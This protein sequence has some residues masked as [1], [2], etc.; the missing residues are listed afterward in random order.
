M[1]THPELLDWL[2][3]DFM[4]HGWDVKRLARMIALSGTFAQGTT[5]QDPATLQSDPENRWLARG[6][7]VRL[8][9]EEVRDQAL[10]ASGLLCSHVGGPSVHAYM[11]RESYRDAALQQPFI[12]DTGDKLHRRSIYSFW[13]R[14]LPPPELAA[15]DAPSREFCVVKREKTTSPA[16]ALMLLN[17]TQFVEAQRVLAQ[18]LVRDFRDD[19]AARCATAFRL[20]TTRQ[21]TGP[22]MDALVRLVQH[23]REYF[24]QH[25]SSS[26]AL[27][28]TNGDAPVDPSV[29]SIEAAST[30]MMVRALM[31][32]D[33]AL[34]R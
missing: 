1:P 29:P 32:P 28:A 9:A 3:C 5:P 31:S 16:Q 8:T 7:R 4:K 13:R 27:L 20:L 26:D 30:T 12:Q 33:E 23:Q 24:E 21:A 25:P 22:E 17:Q 6:P 34:N 11:P 15:F 18:Q 19:P 2:A 10:A 14:T